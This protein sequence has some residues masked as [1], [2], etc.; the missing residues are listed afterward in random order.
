[1]SCVFVEINSVN[2]DSKITIRRMRCTHA[3]ISQNYSK[4]M[5]RTI[6]IAKRRARIGRSSY[7]FQCWMT[8][9]DQVFSFL[10]FYLEKLRHMVAMY[11]EY[12]NYLIQTHAHTEDNV[13]QTDRMLTEDG[14]TISLPIWQSQWNNL[15]KTNDTYNAAQNDAW[16]ESEMVLSC[17]REKERERNMRRSCFPLWTEIE[18]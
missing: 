9:N 11:L 12:S 16:W 7:R 6:V 10:I 1:M 18:E 2:D 8:S 13:K 3:V 17:V 14:G 4:P 15:V 5:I